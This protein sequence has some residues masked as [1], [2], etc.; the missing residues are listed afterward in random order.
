RLHEEMLRDEFGA[1]LQPDLVAL[2][3]KIRTDPPSR[4]PQPHRAATPATPIAPEVHSRPTSIAVLP[5]ADTSAGR[6]NEYFSEGLMEEIGTLLGGVGGLRVA[7]RTSALALRARGLGIQEVG[8][9][10][11][12]H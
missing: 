7:A 9:L 6:G 2:V 3:A 5:F 11:H 4:P 8:R 10:L 1:E 12:V